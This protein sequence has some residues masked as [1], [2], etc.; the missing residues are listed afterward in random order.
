MVFF[1]GLEH[2]KFKVYFLAA[3]D[4]Q[5]YFSYITDKSLTY[6]NLATCLVALHVSIFFSRPNATWNEHLLKLMTI[7]GD[8]CCLKVKY[9]T[10]FMVT[11]LRQFCRW[12]NDVKNYYYLKPML[13]LIA[14]VVGKIFW[15]LSPAKDSTKK[16]LLKGETPVIPFIIS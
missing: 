13:F 4:S 8:S 14:K 6:I 9:L 10:I 2:P 5:K 1:N 3:Y 15:R 7:S 16:F 11:A 12:P